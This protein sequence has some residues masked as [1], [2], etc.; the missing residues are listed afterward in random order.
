MTFSSHLH[1]L[2][3]LLLIFSAIGFSLWAYRTTLP[4]VS[5]RKKAV[6]VSLRSVTL[7]LLVLLVAEPML[8]I[9]RTFFRQPVIALMA[10]NSLSMTLTD[11][12]GSR[13]QQLRAIFADDAW[14]RLSSDGLVRRYGIAPVFSSVQP[15][16]LAL[17][18]ASTDLAAALSALLSRDAEPVRAVILL[19]DGNYNIGANPLSVAERF[20][21][22][23]FTVGIG[24]ST[25]QKDVVVSK[26][27]GN[28]IAYIDASVPVD[29]TLKI[30]GAA[31]AS[32]RVLLLEDGREVDRTAVT[33]SSS[34]DAAEYPVRFVYVPKAEGVRKISVRAVPLTGEATEKNNTRSFAM[35]VLKNKMRIV[36]VAGAPGP[37]AAAVMQTLLGDKNCD[38][39]LFY[40]TGS[41]ELRAER[42]AAT[43]AAAV[44]GADCIVLVGFPTQ[45]TTIP[46][47]QTIL[48]AARS[49]D[50]PLLFIS[51]RTVDLEKLK[52]LEPVLPFTVAGARIDEQ[53]VMAAIPASQQSNLLM[54]AGETAAGW[55]KLPPI[56]SSISVFKAKPEAAV[57]AT[58]R[59]QGVTLSVPLIVTR[60]VGA[61]K[62]F[63]VLGYGIARWK[64]LAGASS[65]TASFFTSWFTAA[66]RW[67]AVRDEDKRLRVEP[68]KE[69]FSQGEP[70][71]LLG[72]AYSE[73]YDPLDNAELT[74]EAI[75]QAS[76]QKFSTTLAGV[77][78]GRYEGTFLNLAEGEYEYTG[79][80][81]LSGHP[82][83]TV[84]GRFSV[85][86]QSLE[87]TDTKLNTTLMRQIASL[88]GG[89]YASGA[90][91][92][93]LIDRMKAGGMLAP[94]EETGVSEVDMWSLPLLFALILLSAG[95]EWFLRKRS[96][97]V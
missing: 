63:A 8:R 20:P 80:A 51:G 25:E 30:S 6:L 40:Q 91:Y 94:E 78:S 9:S 97:M 42:T 59:I 60:T 81:S 36:A 22:P 50:L 64:L 54:S 45:Q 71:A 14:D 66:T 86:E 57:L 13:E 72:Q 76:K 44:A 68:G 32:V 56:F 28:A 88:S 41:G 31:G 61:Q 58:M 87:F 70:A 29:A 16:S 15:E 27:T 92:R 79:T 73:T 17:R 47:L 90:E 12:S 48:A 21:A 34:A 96:G 62:S 33:V 93:S 18:G 23:I 55:E 43:L 3:L 5:R 67:L 35:K 85:G 69:I 74:V 53:Q 65:E 95:T 37:D 84:R 89:A 1:W 52:L 75:E 19:S 11:A 4:P 26:I 2:L 7:V 82:F 39:A 83:A 46:H 77:G 38:P 49:K 10:D 24:D